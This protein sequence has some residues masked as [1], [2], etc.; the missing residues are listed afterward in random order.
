MQIDKLASISLLPKLLI[1]AL[2]DAAVGLR[3]R[4]SSS[5]RPKQWNACK[6]STKP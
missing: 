4:L 6:R 5:T 2:W 3:F 1:T